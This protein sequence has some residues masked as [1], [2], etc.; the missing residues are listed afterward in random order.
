MRSPGL[1]RYRRAVEA[2]PP[3][4]SSP[5]CP[6]RLVALHAFRSQFN[7]AA[8]RTRMNSGEEAELWVGS[9]KSRSSL[10]CPAGLPMPRVSAR[11]EK[12]KAVPAGRC[13]RDKGNPLACAFVASGEKDLNDGRNAASD[14]RLNGEE[15]PAIIASILE[16]ERDARARPSPAADV[17]RRRSCCGKIEKL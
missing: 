16:K 14:G 10:S 9:P 12:N 15:C 6:A 1:L 7:H 17:G 3:A 5:P 11:A 2:V 4:L 8:T 13:E